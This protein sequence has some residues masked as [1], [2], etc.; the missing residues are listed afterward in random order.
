MTP[1]HGSAAVDQM[2]SGGEGAEGSVQRRN[3]SG[4]TQARLRLK[5]QCRWGPVARPGHADGA[6][7]GARGDALAGFHV[8][9][10]QMAVH[11]DQ[12]AAVIDEHGIAVEK[13]IAR[14]DH[15]ACDGA[16]TGVP[17]GAAMSMPLCGLR[18]SPLKMRRM[19]NELLRTPG[20]GC[21]RRSDLGRLRRSSGSSRDR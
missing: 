7:A 2:L 11:A 1:A 14:V 5:P 12:A 6:D 13:I 4:S 16:S 3:N 9:R 15:G 10:A 8:D 17:T 21:G 19:P 20:T 18:D